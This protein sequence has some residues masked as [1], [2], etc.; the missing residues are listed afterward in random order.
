MNGIWTTPSF[1]EWL[2]KNGKSP[3][4]RVRETFQPLPPP[5]TRED[6][7]WGYAHIRSLKDAPVIG[8]TVGDV[9]A[10]EVADDGSLTQIDHA[11]P[12]KLGSTWLVEWK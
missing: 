2:A 10:F 1:G 3:F 7:K 4:A 12:V 11:K 9:I 6:I 5:P 8:V